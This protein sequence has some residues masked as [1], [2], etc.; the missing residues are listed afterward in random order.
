MRS[1]KLIAASLLSLFATIL[2]I[3]IVYRDASA[4]DADFF[5][6]AKTE[7]RK[8][9][10]GPVARLMTRAYHFQNHS[11]FW[12]LIACDSR[13]LGGCE[14]IAKKCM[15]ECEVSILADWLAA[16]PDAKVKESELLELKDK[17]NKC[18]APCVDSFKACAI[19]SG[20]K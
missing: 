16:D 1:V 10:N 7:L 19:E 8:A 15:D 6:D 13:A 14:E 4:G 18:Q 9:E 2:C 17:I 20:C 3:T 11:K 12:K 5:Q